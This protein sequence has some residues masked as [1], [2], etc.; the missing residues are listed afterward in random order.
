MV[1]KDIIFNIDLNELP[2]EVHPDENGEVNVGSNES[3]GFKR[4]LKRN[5]FC[6][7]SNLFSIG[8]EIPPL[9]QVNF[10]YVEIEWDMLVVL[11]LF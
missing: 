9:R 2:T 7:C 4:I 10:V 5:C 3:M 8:Y 6:F 11:I 1:S